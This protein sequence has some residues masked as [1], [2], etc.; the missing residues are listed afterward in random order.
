M[1]VPAR[2][3]KEILAYK[4]EEVAERKRQYTVGELRERAEEQDKPRGFQRALQASVAQNKATIIAE[5]KRASPSKG[6]LREDFDPLTI[7][8]SYM[9]GG[10]T[11]LSVLTDNKFFKSSGA[12]LDLVRRHCPLPALRKDF[13][14]DEYQVYESRAFGADCMLLI[15]VAT[16][17]SQLRD[18]FHLA[19]EQN[20]D[21][22]VEVHNAAELEDALALGDILRMIGINNRDLHTFEVDLQ[23]TLDLVS[24]I[25]GDK[26][27]VSESGIGTYADIEQLMNVGVYAYLIGESLITADNPGERLKA[28]LAQ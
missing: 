10:A 13:I 4:R 8:R 5:L 20:M 14:I 18:L 28:L 2:F 24:E 26:L 11:C 17:G 3:L 25:P 12:I 6:V 21:V 22:L 16:S 15:V 1:T 23:T 7:A 9:I 19:N 27:I